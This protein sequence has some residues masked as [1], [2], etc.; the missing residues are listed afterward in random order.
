M[1][2]DRWD[3]RTAFVLA[4]IGSAIGLGNIWRFPYVCYKSGGGAFLIAYLV[5]LFTVGIPLL[6]LEFNLGHKTESAAPRAFKKVN[7]RLEFFGWGAI[8]V[9]FVI[10]TYYAVVMAWCIYYGASAAS[11]AWGGMA[12]GDNPNDFFY[13]DVL[14]ISEGPLH[15]GGWNPLVFG[16]LILAWILIVLSIWKGAKTVGKVVYLTVLLP[17][18]LLIIFVVRGVTL[19]GAVDGLNFYLTPQWHML[20]NA[21]IWLQAYTQVFFSVSLGFG[22]M[23]AY[24]SFLP[25]TADITN[26]A[27]II[28]LADAATAFIGGLAVFGALGF[29]AQ[30]I[31]IDTDDWLEELRGLNSVAVVA[32]DVPEEEGKEYLLHL[33][34]QPPLSKADAAVMESSPYLLIARDIPD[35]PSLEEMLKSGALPL[36]A[37]LRGLLDAQ[38][39]DAAES[40]PEEPPTTVL[41]AVN[42]LIETKFIYDKRAFEGVKL[43]KKLEKAVNGAVEK[44]PKGASLVDLNRQLLVAGW[45]DLISESLPTQAEVRR[46]ERVKGF[47]GTVKYAVAPAIP[48]DL[49]PEAST[50]IPVSIVTKSGPGLTF[51]TYPTIINNLPAVPWLFGVLFFLMLLMLAVDSAFSLVEAAAASLRD[52]WGWSHRRSNLTIAAIGLVMGVPF[53]LGFGLYWLDLVDRFMNQFGLTTIC[54]GEC[55]FLGWAIK[56]K[57]HKPIDMRV[58]ARQALRWGVGSFLAA[59][60]LL[61]AISVAVS[62]SEGG[63]ASWARFAEL[64]P[65]IVVGADAVALFAVIVVFTSDH[66]YVE[67]LRLYANE[68]SDFSI[69]RWWNFLVRYI[70][71]IV[72]MF[73]IVKEVQARI[74]APYEG[75]PR[76]ALFI[77]G[78][79]LLHIMVFMAFFLMFVR[80]KT[81]EEAPE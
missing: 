78:W 20:L 32:L 29:H 40:P 54:L 4:S 16:C 21:D 1:A 22:I 36:A 12:W 33:V 50:K 41:A 27:C 18:L 69:G 71:P 52:K 8:L 37:H 42:R 3:S 53:A 43:G 25:R 51:V 74:G 62:I 15:L 23:I 81:E 44:P 80:G 60:A 61:T 49:D 56:S 73:L 63:G 72:L 66:R 26:N 48:E 55:I 6:I 24:A 79:L 64:I 9:A 68:Q 11:L 76:I 65:I 28:G 59:G 58:C 13:N 45:P 38:E 34:P 57:R 7:K 30:R 14:R 2:R 77:G 5:A 67:D 75:Y 35:G 47:T 10:C 70:A 39:A 46:K 17:W 19:P 31:E